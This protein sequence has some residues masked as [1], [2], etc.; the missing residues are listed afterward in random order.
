VLSRR[1]P[2][3]VTISAFTGAYLILGNFWAVLVSCMFLTAIMTVAAMLLQTAV[4]SRK[5]YQREA[6][7]AL[8]ELIIRS[9]RA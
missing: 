2:A 4:R 8:I 1:H 6:A 7:Y 5:K 9:Q 3:A